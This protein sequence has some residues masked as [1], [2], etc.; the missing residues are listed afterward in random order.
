MIA[1]KLAV[2][3]GILY[4]ISLIMQIVLVAGTNINQ[5]VDENI[6]SW[7]GA[8]CPLFGVFE[9][10][11]WG[12]LLSAFNDGQISFFI[13]GVF[14]L[15][16]LIKVG[17]AIFVYYNLV[18]DYSNGDT[19]YLYEK[20][21][22]TVTKI[23]KKVEEEDTTLLNT[24]VMIIVCMS[25]I[26][27]VCMTISLP[28]VGGDSFKVKRNPEACMKLGQNIFDPEGFC[29]YICDVDTD[30][31]T[32]TLVFSFFIIPIIYPIEVYVDGAFDKCTEAAITP[33]IWGILIGS[34]AL[35]ALIWCGCMSCVRS[36][37]CKDR[38]GHIPLGEEKQR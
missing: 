9:F 2:S 35:F 25:I 19:K 5:S 6:V 16:F 38:V 1:N 37:K 28:I 32:V 33:L 36:C 31:Y 30:L 7:M 29:D 34:I 20:K 17:L 21:T 23:G 18:I 4:L 8:S 10:I 27:L 26:W 11:V 24:M 12:D 3:W 22:V 13:F 14:S 15:N